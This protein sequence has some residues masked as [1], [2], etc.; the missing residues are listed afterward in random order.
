MDRLTK[1]DFFSI[2]KATE[3]SWRS[4][5]GHPRSNL[6]MRREGRILCN[7]QAIGVINDWFNPDVHLPRDPTERLPSRIFLTGRLETLQCSQSVHI[8]FDVY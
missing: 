3:S 5:Y 4:L 6:Q 7:C 2:S 8:D 1:G